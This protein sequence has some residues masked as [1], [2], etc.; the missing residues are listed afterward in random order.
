MPDAL[1]P[2]QP[3]ILPKLQQ[4][5]VPEMAARIMTVALELFAQK[6]YAATSVREI[7]Q[8]ADVTNPMLY[9]YFK[10]KA[11][12]FA[13]LVEHLVSSMHEE[14]V[15][16]LDSADNLAE[17]LTNVV[18][19]HFE[20]CRQAPISLKFVYSILFGPEASR[21][22]AD[23]F[24]RHVCVVGTIAQ[25]FEEAMDAGE[26]TAHQDHSPLFLA[27]QY[28]G[29]INSH[30]MRTL[31]ITESIESAQK[32]RDYLDELLSQDQG[33]RLVDFFLNGAGRIVE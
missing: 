15:E 5:D 19:R 27:H 32:R 30:L 1:T 8:Q 31:K 21:P 3:E 22:K 18:A 6:G 9:Y 33:R 24:T 14:V 23:I 2:D 25:T 13:Q 10:S 29:L 12:L 11:G 26:F 17:K 4:S 16:V 20:A 28:F 7:V